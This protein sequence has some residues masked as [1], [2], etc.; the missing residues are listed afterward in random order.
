MDLSGAQI[1]VTTA[2]IL[3][4]VFTIEWGLRKLVF[5]ECDLDELVRSTSVPLMQSHS[6]FADAE[7]YASRTLDSRDPFISFSCI[8]QATESPRIQDYRRI[9]VEGTYIHIH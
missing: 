9:R 7:T 5:R 1:T 2:A 3:S 6:S 4:D 8:K